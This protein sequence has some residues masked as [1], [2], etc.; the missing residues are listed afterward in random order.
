MIVDLVTLV[1]LMTLVWKGRNDLNVIKY[2]N[3]KFGI[4]LYIIRVCL[5]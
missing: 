5:D 4:L 2:I 3:G 1:T